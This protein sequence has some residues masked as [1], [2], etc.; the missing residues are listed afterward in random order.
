MIIRLNRIAF[1]EKTIC[2]FEVL[3]KKVCICVEQKNIDSTD[4]STQTFKHL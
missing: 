1:M 4:L 2:D 3:K